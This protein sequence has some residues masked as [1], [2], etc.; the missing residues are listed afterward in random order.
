MYR[1]I[2]FFIFCLNLIIS[3]THQSFAANSEL[4]RLLES[5]ALHANKTQ[6]LQANFTQK[7]QLSFLK[8]PLSSQ[9]HLFFTKNYE[10]EPALLWEYL[11][12]APSG[13]LF[14]RNESWMWLQERSQLKKAHGYEGNVLNTMIKQM[15]LWFTFE[16]NNLKNHYAMDLQST[17]TSEDESCIKLI[18]KD[19]SFFSSMHLCINNQAYTINSITFMEQQGDSTSL[20]F[21]DIVLNAKFP[22]SFPDGT[23]FP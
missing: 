15:L 4:D 5:M 6:S 10:N 18:P 19:D 17:A 7:K 23:P 20:Q 1:N 8:T 22:T 14:Q 16:P 13:I 2:L 11:N 9:G 3:S 21:H 12:P